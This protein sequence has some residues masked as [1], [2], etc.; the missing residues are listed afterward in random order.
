M[1]SY[2][3][4]G[5]G[6]LLLLGAVLAFVIVGTL[7]FISS[8]G[9]LVSADEAHL[10]IRLAFRGARSI[11]WSQLKPGRIYQAFGVVPVLVVEPARI[12]FLSNPAD[13]ILVLR[14]PAD[15]PVLAVISKRIGLS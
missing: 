2:S 1:R 6:P 10:H 11:P 12:A 3:V 5:L 13:F 14:L 15:D 8:I 7:L 9:R 4:I